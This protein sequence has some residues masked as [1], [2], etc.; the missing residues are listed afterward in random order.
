MEASV[1]ADTPGSLPEPTD[2]PSAD[3]DALEGIDAVLDILN[4]I[5]C[6]YTDAAGAQRRAHMQR[7]FDPHAARNVQHGP[8]APERAMQ[9]REDERARAHVVVDA[10]RSRLADASGSA[11]HPARFAFWT[12]PC[13]AWCR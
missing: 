5:Q 11:T 9:R 2:L 12:T 13:P 4:N 3:G 8:A 7:L 6:V 1:D 10:P